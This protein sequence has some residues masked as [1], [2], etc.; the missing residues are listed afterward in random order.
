M[1]SFTYTIEG[2]DPLHT[3]PVLGR[4]TLAAK[5]DT[6]IG[7]TYGSLTASS[8]NKVFGSAAQVPSEATSGTAWAMA[9]AGVP[10]VGGVG[11]S[12]QFGNN[13]MYD[14][15]AKLGL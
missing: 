9:G 1:T 4:T 11:G 14:E 15:R 8:T 5:L 12:N 7:A 13:Y 6:D 3:T 10:L 2:N